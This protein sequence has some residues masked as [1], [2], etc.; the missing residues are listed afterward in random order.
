V[1]PSLF[2]VDR[3]DRLRPSE[4]PDGR[5][6]GGVRRGG[7]FSEGIEECVGCSCTY[8]LI[9]PRRGNRFPSTGPPPADRRRLTIRPRGRSRRAAQRDED[10][11]KQGQPSTTEART[12]CSSGHAPL[13][14]RGRGLPNRF[15]HGRRPR[16][17]H[18]VSSRAMVRRPG[19]HPRGRDEDVGPA[20][21]QG[22]R[23]SMPFPA[24]SSLPMTSPQV[25]WPIQVAAKLKGPRHQG[26]ARRPA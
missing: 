15:P 6:P 18:G 10:H 17:A 14:G 3:T 20:W 12:G 4:N 5:L 9:G 26:R 23:E 16:R 8:D 21:S 19:R 2:V 25:H 1:R 7:P 22:R 13:G 24:P 11:Q